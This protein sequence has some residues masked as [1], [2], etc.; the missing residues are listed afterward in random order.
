MQQADWTGADSSCYLTEAIF[1]YNNVKALENSML[2]SQNAD[3]IWD[4]TDFV[5][6]T[7]AVLYIEVIK[8]ST[9]LVY[10]PAVSYASKTILIQAIVDSVNAQGTFTAVANGNFIN[11]TSSDPNTIGVTLTLNIVAPYAIVNSTLSPGNYPYSIA[12]DASMQGT[13][14]V[15]NPLD[16]KC[17]VMGDDGTALGAAISF[18][19][20]NNLVEQQFKNDYSLETFSLNGIP[21]GT[22]VPTGL[23]MLTGNFDGVQYQADAINASDRSLSFSFFPLDPDNDGVVRQYLYNPIND[24]IYIKVVR[25]S[26]SRSYIVITDSACTVQSTILLAN[27][28]AHSFDYF[29]HPAPMT[30]DPNTGHVYLTSKELVLVVDGDPT[31]GTYN[32]VIFEYASPRPSLYGGT[33][34]WNSGSMLVNFFSSGT[35]IEY[36][37]EMDT[38]GNFTEVLAETGIFNI[39]IANGFLVVN[40]RSVANPTNDTL[41]KIVLYN[42]TDYS[43]IST[44]QTVTAVYYI[45]VAAQS[46]QSRL[47]WVYDNTRYF[48]V[49]ESVITTFTYDLTFAPPAADTNPCFSTSQQNNIINHLLD[50]CGCSGASEV[51]SFGDSVNAL[52][53][54]NGN[55]IDGNGDYIQV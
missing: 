22:V 29:T 42:L 18:V 16:D 53:D 21:A 10:V 45:S 33:V 54:G 3:A 8:T 41:N 13:T 35:A 4:L 15:Y 27:D 11:V 20:I 25:T 26:T 55:A 38:S 5:L 50:K 17:W 7:P 40:Y 24:N 52:G 23:S 14:S 31:S 9:Q 37:Y 2:V 48:A 19:D 32:T 36:V 30:Y 51:G 44:T 39:N 47:T 34:L 12:L 28:A 46:D 49:M 1:L 43:V 6:P